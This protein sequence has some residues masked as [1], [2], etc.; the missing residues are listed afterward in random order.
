M[1]QK[2]A[3]EPN[4]ALLGGDTMSAEESGMMDANRD[5]EG[6][7]P[8]VEAEAEQPAAAAEAKP[9]GAPLEVEDHEEPAIDPKTGKERVVNYGALHA[10]RQ[11]RKTAETE[12]AKGREENAKLM[13]R[14][15]TLQQLAQRQQPAKQEPTAEV[16]DINIDPVGH[17]QA[18]YQQSQQKIAD[19]DKWRQSQEANATARNNV[20]ELG[21]LAQQSEGEFIKTTPDYPDAFQYITKQRDQELQDMGYTD[22]GQRQ[23][24]MQTD[25]LQ[26][27]A[28]ALSG[29]KSPAEV[30]YK[31][32]QA[33]GYKIKEAPLVPVKVSE[34]ADGKKI[35]TI[36][37]GQS[38]NTSL[39]QIGGTSIPEF[40][41]ENIAKMSDSEFEK[42][43]T[44]D[45]WRK[46]MGG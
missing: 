29:K 11:K 22:P 34:T 9:A 35:A 18:L 14:F 27:A 2:A 46:M 44:D 40:S 42:W 31:I 25:A 17:F 13:G 8:E 3:R 1:A 28:Q 32:A 36:A 4:A 19:I 7:S 15:E 12:A 30:V 6:S 21:R 24:I 41:A 26:I 10:E 43:A 39:G 38:A 37:K 16:P 20:Q 45:N 5:S 33:R 23:Q